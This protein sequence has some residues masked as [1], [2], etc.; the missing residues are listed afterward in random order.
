MRVSSVIRLCVPAVV[1]ASMLTCGGK[2]SSPTG[3]TPP[4]SVPPTTV[5][6]PSP[7][8]PP[9]SDLC[10]RLPV[11]TDPGKSKCSETSSV[12]SGEVAGA[13]DRVMAQ[14]PSLFSGG[15][16]TSVGEYYVKVLD[17]LRA[18]GYCAVFDGEEIGVRQQ[19]DF[20]EQF[21][22]L[23]SSNFVV[24]GGAS[25]KSTCTPSAI[26]TAVA[27]LPPP[28]AGCSLPSSRE[29]ACGADA[30]VY[31]DDM[32]AGLDDVIATHPEL[33]NLNHSKGLPNAYEVVD[34][35]GYIQA[36][37]NAMIK[38]GF[39]AHFDGEELVLKKTND[40]SA[41]FDILTGDNY[42]RRGNGMYRSSCWPAAF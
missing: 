26:P 16:A 14:N 7:T 27:P 20:N 17:A 2:S 25:Y 24:Q 29:V 37:T 39:C 30:P 9:V 4:P 41:H 6:V 8:P 36:A 38:R 42:M 21:H 15:K 22:V 11:V 32:E 34:V 10:K 18:D 40:F 28:V 1:A 13:I 5:P 19:D 12:F 23:T 3:N 31:L 33:F 35:N